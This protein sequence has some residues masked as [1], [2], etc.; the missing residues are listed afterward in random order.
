MA[1]AS[2]VFINTPLPAD[3]QLPRRLFPEVY[4]NGDRPA[5]CGVIDKE[6]LSP[7]PSYGFGWMLPSVELFHA[8]DTTDEDV[9]LKMWLFQLPKMVGTLL[10]PRWK[11]KGYWDERR[12]K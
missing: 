12:Y 10:Y 5:R 9:P 11:M 4:T 7:T 1:V 2:C 3:L 6:R 8:I